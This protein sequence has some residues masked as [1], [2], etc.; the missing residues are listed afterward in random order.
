M[1][2]PNSDENVTTTALRGSSVSEMVKLE[3]ALPSSAT[4]CV[5][6]AKDT[7]TPAC[8]LPVGAAVGAK[9]GTGGGNFVGLGV[10]C[11][12]GRDDGSDVG[13]TVGREV[14][15]VLGNQR[16]LM[17]S[18]CRIGHAGSCVH[19]GGYNPLVR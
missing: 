5:W 16:F 3:V 2:A 18:P 17:K 15:T 12:E 19:S 10:G 8:G 6:P 7:A 13:C 14:G 4:A 11:R 1:A 9:V